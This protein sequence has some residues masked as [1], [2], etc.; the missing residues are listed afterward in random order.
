MGLY[1]LNL[2]E[3]SEYTGFTIDELKERSYTDLEFMMNNMKNDKIIARNNRNAQD[4]EYERLVLKY[5]EP[6]QFLRHWFDDKEIVFACAHTGITERDLCAEMVVEPGH[7]CLY[8]N[9]EY[10]R[11]STELVPQYDTYGRELVE[12]KRKKMDV[13]RVVNRYQ[14][15]RHG[16]VV[17]YLLYR[18]YPELVQF[19]FSAYSMS[20]E[21]NYEIYPNN[22][23][24]VP[25][26]ALMS[27]DIDAII[28]RNREY[29]KQYNNGRFSPEECEKAFHTEEVLHMFDIIRKI[30]EKERAAGRH[31]IKLY[32]DGTVDAGSLKLVNT[33]EISDMMLLME[34]QS[35]YNIL[36]DRRFRLECTLAPHSLKHVVN[37]YLKI[38]NA[39]F[40]NIHIYHTTDYLGEYS[41]DILSVRKGETINDDA[42]TLNGFNYSDQIVHNTFGWIRGNTADLIIRIVC[43]L[44]CK[45]AH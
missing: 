15:T 12:R 31:F 34:E 5:F 11:T 40:V 9:N 30:G 13:Y 45:M 35:K 29:C 39:D 10:L 23:V 36:R 24:Y 8:K 28:F 41:V 16:E 18:R 43:P 17:L 3:L 25:F 38:T 20:H 33:S 37:E 1:Y 14:G 6:V 19:G 2:D 44:I 42:Y 4:D 21:P 27:G 32:D 22:H 26:A 7:K